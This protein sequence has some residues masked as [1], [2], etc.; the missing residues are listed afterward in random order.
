LSEYG[1]LCR[2]FMENMMIIDLVCKMEIDE[3]AAS[4]SLNYDGKDYFFCSEGCVEEFTR[5]PLDYVESV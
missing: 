3:E 4:Y 1:L 5:R 2:T